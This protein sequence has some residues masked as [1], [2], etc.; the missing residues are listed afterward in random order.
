MLKVISLM[1]FVLFM[2]LT[3][4]LSIKYTETEEN[5]RKARQLGVGAE[6]CFILSVLLEIPGSR[7]GAAGLLAV[8]VVTGLVL[9]LCR[10]IGSKLNRAESKGTLLFRGMVRLSVINLFFI[11]TAAGVLSHIYDGIAEVA[12]TYALTQNGQ[13]IVLWWCPAVVFSFIASIFL[14]SDNLSKFGKMLLGYFVCASFASMLLGDISTRVFG[15]SIT[16]VIDVIWGIINGSGYPR[17]I[18]VALYLIMR[19]SGLYVICLFAGGALAFGMTVVRHYR[20]IHNN[21]NAMPVVSVEQMRRADEYTIRQGTSGRELMHRAALGIYRA[22]D[23][24]NKNVAIVTGSGNNGGDG[25]ALAAILAENGV[26][27]ALYRTSE[28]FSDDGRFYYERAKELGVCD[29]MFTYDTDLSGY[30]IVVDCILGTGFKGVPR[31]LVADAIAAINQSGAYIICADI[32]SGLNGDTGEAVLAVKSDITVSI[33]FYK[34]GMFKA[35]EN[36]FIGELINV[37]IGIAMV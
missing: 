15:S 24:R 30:N 34:K 32:N 16:Q 4:P 3:A 28:S 33:G 22:A 20:R 18:S 26:F 17:N 10:F 2:G 21:P 37:D 36:G 5:S 12:S 9:L 7:F 1:L 35:V 6:I 23:W 19:L 27:A 13:K 8:G 11:L 25:Y 29:E 31:G 14:V